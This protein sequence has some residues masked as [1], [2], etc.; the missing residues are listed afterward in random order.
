MLNTILLGRKKNLL[1]QSVCC[2]SPPGAFQDA[3]LIVLIPFP[4]IP[5]LGLPAPQVS[6]VLGKIM[7]RII[8]LCHEAGNLRWRMAQKQLVPPPFPSH[9]SYN[10]FSLQMQR[11]IGSLRN[12][13]EP[14]RKSCCSCTYKELPLA[15]LFNMPPR[16]IRNIFGH[17]SHTKHTDTH[18]QHEKELLG[19]RW[20]HSG[21]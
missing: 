14:S 18:S 1:F 9:L 12:H 8:L 3:P 7:K 17:W 15:P 5:L 16:G 20:M 10:V 21:G 6:I 2:L 11:A 4:E 19:T 13:I